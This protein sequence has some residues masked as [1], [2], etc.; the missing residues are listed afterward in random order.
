MSALTCSVFPDPLLASAETAPAAPAAG[1][2]APSADAGDAATI[3]VQSTAP[4]DMQVKRSPSYKFTAPLLDAALGHVIPEQL[5]R[6]N[7]T[8]FADAL[9]RCRA[10]RSSAATRPRTRRPIAR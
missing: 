6:K 2:P 5:I 1:Q 7:V 8:S 3:N 9:R 10:S 4:S